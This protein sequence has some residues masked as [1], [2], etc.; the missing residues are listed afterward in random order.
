MT[1]TDVVFFFGDPADRNSLYQ[2]KQ[3]LGPLERLATH[4]SVTVICA[5]DPAA[6]LVRGRKGLTCIQVR[7]I[8][9]GAAKLWDVTPTVVLYPNQFF[10]NFAAWSYPN[11]AHVFVSHGESDK[12]YMSQNCIKFFDFAYV[13]GEVAEKRIQ[14]HVEGFATD[15]CIRIGRPQM[16]DDV[17]PPPKQWK[18]DP[19]RTIVLY[20]PTWEGG[21]TQN[22]YGSVMSHGRAMVESLLARSDEFQ[23]IYKPHPFTGSIIP[24]WRDEDAAIAELVAAA[25]RANPA[26][27]HLDDRGPFGWQLTD[28]S[29]MI[30]DVSAVAYDWLSTGKPMVITRPVE[31]DAELYDDG[32]LGAVELLDVADAGTVAELVH[33]AMADPASEK[34]FRDWGSRYFES[35][36]DEFGVERFIA[37]TINLVSHAPAQRALTAPKTRDREKPQTAGAVQ[38]LRAIPRQLAS[39]LLRDVVGRVVLAVQGNGRSA[40]DI[41]LVDAEIKPLSV[42]YYRSLDA[43]LPAGLRV[44]LIVL[45][46]GNW[47]RA[48]TLSATESWFR[49]RFA[50]TFA[51][52]PQD[53]AVAI[54]AA[55]ASTIYYARHTASNHFGVRLNG[56]RHVLLYP[57]FHRGFAADH[58]LNAYSAIVTADESCAAT[59]TGFGTSVHDIVIETFDESRTSANP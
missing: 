52:P 21:L 50:V 18:P 33:T 14:S 45:G 26:A 6:D 41:T 44:R 25:N 56:L 15:R 4:L 51:P 57:E 31:K 3:W 40:F 46:A 39:R 9:E 43:A 29:V 28:A 2:L 59:V 42:A 16:L 12:T 10:R 36:R 11:A 58:N 19:S 54:R 17:V 13:A 7:D 55:D 53:T 35:V 47:L 23:V 34:F 32:I 22:R 49:A 37:E 38:R 30:T 5:S 27:G 20:A 48:T 8:Y 24:A 1:S